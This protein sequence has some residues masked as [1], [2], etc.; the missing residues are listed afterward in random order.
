MIPGT[1]IAGDSSWL[2]NIIASQMVQESRSCRSKLTPRSTRA[3]AAE[4]ME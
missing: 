3:A 1:L 2:Q 4:V